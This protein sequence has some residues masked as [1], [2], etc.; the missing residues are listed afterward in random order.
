[1]FIGKPSVPYIPTRWTVF[2]DTLDAISRNTGDISRNAGRYFQTRWTVY[3]ET[4]SNTFQSTKRISE[5]GV[6]HAYGSRKTRA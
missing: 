4:P 5:K 6:A 3:A 1:M 2:P